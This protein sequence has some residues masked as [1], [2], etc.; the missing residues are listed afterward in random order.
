[1]PKASAEGEQKTRVPKTKKETGDN[2]PVGEVPVPA[3]TPVSETPLATEE[4]TEK[5]AVGAKKRTTK[6]KA[7]GKKAADE[8]PPT[9][10]D[11]PIESSAD[12]KL[13]ASDEHKEAEPAPPATPIPIQAI[14]R[15]PQAPHPESEV[16]VEVGDPELTPTAAV[17]VLPEDEP[18]ADSNEGSKD[19]KTS[20]YLKFGIPA[21]VAAGFL[22]LTLGMSSNNRNENVY[23]TG[24][25]VAPKATVVG[26]SEAA[27][28]PA[29]PT[30][31]PTNLPHNGETVNL[32]PGPVIIVIM[33]YGTKPEDFVR[34]GAL[35][36]PSAPEQRTLVPYT[37]QK[38]EW[39][40][41]IAR[42]HG[43]TL[44]EVLAANPGIVDPDVIRQDQVINLPVKK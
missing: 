33:D 24:T 43:L 38:G 42:D 35:T 20:T 15:N 11:L 16:A 10:T 2:K 18:P 31:E 22:L 9:P 12:H 4:E 32:P 5:L 28:P 7:A 17:I 41:K 30:F 23:A 27:E 1:M 40:N 44:A 36:T 34:P 13:P 29:G 19:R 8:T 37:V 3:I 39:L 26:T 6:A 25:A 14:G 21:S